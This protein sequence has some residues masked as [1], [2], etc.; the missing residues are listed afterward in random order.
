EGSETVGCACRL[1]MSE[2]AHRAVAITAIGRRGGSLL[3]LVRK[4]RTGGLF[5]SCAVCSVPRGAACAE[6]AAACFEQDLFGGPFY[7]LRLL[8]SVHFFAFVS[9]F[10]SGAAAD[11]IFSTNGFRWWLVQ[12]FEVT[13]TTYYH[14]V[15]FPHTLRLGGICSCSLDGSLYNF[16]SRNANAHVLYASYLA[17]SFE[18]TVAVNGYWNMFIFL[19]ER[20]IQLSTPSLDS[21]SGSTPISVEEAFVSVIG[22]DRSGGIRCEGSQ[23][24]RRTWYGTREGSSSTDYQQHISNIEN[25]LRME[26]EELRIE[27]R[28]RDSEMDEMRRELEQLRKRESEMDDIRRQMLQMST[29]MTQFQ[30]SQRFVVSAPPRVP[31]DDHAVDISPNL[32]RSDPMYRWRKAVDISRKKS[33]DN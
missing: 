24:T 10:C 20:M 31:E 23:E 2:R 30:T 6:G 12:W 9:L 25:T 28:R 5:V 16:C 18:E 22:K 27:A 19:Q 7:P 8:L 17:W 11:Q 15:D 1:M 14:A 32:G 26:V 4:C 21:E 3:S 29:F 13:E 33:I